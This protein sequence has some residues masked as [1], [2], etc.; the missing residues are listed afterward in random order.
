MVIVLQAER[1]GAALIVECFFGSLW[2]YP[3]SD[4]KQLFVIA[5]PLLPD[6]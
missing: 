5:Y 2:P 1:E 6:W 3:Y 4:A